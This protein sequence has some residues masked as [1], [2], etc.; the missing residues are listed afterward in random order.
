MI[1]NNKKLSNIL[2]NKKYI[3]IIIFFILFF[4]FDLKESN[5]TCVENHGVCSGL[6]REE[7]PVVQWHNYTHMPGYD[8]CPPGEECYVQEAPCSSPNICKKS[9]ESC[10]KFH[11]FGFCD[12]TKLTYCCGDTSNNNVINDDSKINLEISIAGKSSV[13]DLGDYLVLIY[14]YV[15][16]LAG[17]FAVIMIV[18]A[19]FRWVAAGGNE[20][21]ISGAKEQIKNSIIGLVLVS[22]SYLMLNII[23]PDLVNVHKLNIKK[24]GEEPFAQQEPEEEPYNVYNDPEV[25]NQDANADSEGS[26]INN[27]WERWEKCG[28]RPELGDEHCVPYEFYQHQPQEYQDCET[29]GCDNDTDQCCEQSPP[30]SKQC[31]DISDCGDTYL[32]YCDAGG[33]KICC[34]RKKRELNEGCSHN[35]QC[36]SG[37]CCAWPGITRNDCRSKSYCNNHGEDCKP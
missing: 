31:I 12:G 37:C 22:G 29:G 13:N 36:V 32:G 24:L 15:V 5:A 35:I 21:Q 3:F 30:C 14:K 7:Y 28:N 20:G 6:G 25:H 17:I 19:G 10:S 16:Y 23:N 27:T 26:N 34:S 33:P 18:V 1:Y 4:V 9:T 11:V 8:G 2:K